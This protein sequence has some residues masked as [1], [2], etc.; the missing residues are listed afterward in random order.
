[1]FKRIIINS[2]KEETR[3]AII[4]DEKPT[5][6]FIQRQNDERVVGNI[7]KGRIGKVLPGM[8]SAFVDIGLR[9]HAFLYVSDVFDDMQEYEEFIEPGDPTR[10]GKRSSKNR[11]NE[12]IEE[13]LEE[14]QEILVQVR[15][16]PMGSKGARI[17][18]HM[19]L[20]GRYMVYLPSVQHVGVSRQMGDRRER[21]RLKKIIK[22]LKHPNVGFIVRTAGEGR[23]REDFKTDMTYLTTLWEEIK[24]RAKRS[25]APRLIHAE[26]D[27]VLRILRDYLTFD[28]NEVLIDREEDYIRGRDFIEKFSPKLKKRIKPYRQNF[29]IFERYKIE[30]EIEQSLR[31]QVWLPSGG[32]IVINQTEALVAI[33]VNTGKYVGESNL[34]ETVVDTNLEAVGEIVRQIRLRDLGGIIIVDFIDM[35]ESKNRNKV[36]ETLKKELRKDRSRTRILNLSPFGLVEMTRKRVKSSLNRTLSTTCPYCDGI[37]RIKSNRTICYKIKRE[38]KKQANKV[39]GRVINIRLH[40]DIAQ[41]FRQENNLIRDLEKSIE[42]KITL[43]TD[44]HFHHEQFDILAG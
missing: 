28:L 19:T 39:E 11:S 26:L 20:P 5:E 36:L 34:E 13:L 9:K 24:T 10:K 29:P 4:E 32:Y 8:Q 22:E 15:K 14:G 43:Q 18:T 44:V 2:T 12:A 16:A 7:Y 42:K 41:T 30:E 31:N 21:E 37:G 35:K 38:L 40:P 6:V 3:V 17:S 25:K 27:L 23:N 1:M 33:D